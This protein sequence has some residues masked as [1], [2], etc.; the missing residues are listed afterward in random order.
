MRNNFVFLILFLAQAA[1]AEDK[2]GAS[3]TAPTMNS[4]TRNVVHSISTRYQKLR[5][6]QATFTQETA[7]PALGTTTYNEGRFRFVWPNKFRYSLMRPE[8]EDFIS[9][10]TE[11]WHVVYRE[12]RGKPASVKHFKNVSHLELDRYLLLLKGIEVLTPA[13]EKELLDH[14]LVSGFLKDGLLWLELAPREASEISGI[15]LEFK[16]QD[17]T[18]S[19]AIISDAI[20]AAITVKIITHA[21]WPAKDLTPFLPDFPKG[22]KVEE[23]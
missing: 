11:A 12:G 15:R 14:F 4:E 23:L 20:G 9:N 13:K 10:G 21:A 6:W 2:K 8:S 18:P 1:H 22:S 3:A 16:N 5:N 17:S 19:R 7:N